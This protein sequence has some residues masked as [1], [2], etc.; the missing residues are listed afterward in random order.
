MEPQL[1]SCGLLQP[2]PKVMAS[3][4]FNGAATFQLRI[5]LTLQKIVKSPFWAS[6]EPQLFSCGLGKKGRKEERKELGLQWS[7]NFSVA[8]WST[9]VWISIT[10]RASMEPQLFSCGLQMGIETTFQEY[11]E[12]QWSRN[13][14]VADCLSSAANV[15]HTACFNGAAT[16]QLRIAGQTMLNWLSSFGFNGAATFQLRIE[17]PTCEYLSHQGLQWSRN[18]SVADCRWASKQL[19]K[20]I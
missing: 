5:G 11:L 2:L 20:N 9:D 18:F 14:S 17:V 15:V 16:F 13:F 8:D 4:R 3:W 7:R 19:F 10:S 6:M 1:F 12:L